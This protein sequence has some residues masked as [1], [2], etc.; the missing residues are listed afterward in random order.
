MLGR[1]PAQVQAAEMGCL[2]R[3]LCCT[4]RRSSQL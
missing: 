2:Q 4:S 1:I 3:F